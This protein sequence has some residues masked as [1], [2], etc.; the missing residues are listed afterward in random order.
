MLVSPY[1]I[2]LVGLLMSALLG[3]LTSLYVKEFPSSFKED[4]IRQ[5]HFQKL[6]LVFFFSLMVGDVLVLKYYT[7]EYVPHRIHYLILSL[8]YTMAI[9]SL[10][11]KSN[12]NIPLYV[13]VILSSYVFGWKFL[14]YPLG[15]TDVDGVYHVGNI[16]YLLNTHNL[17]SIPSSYKE[18][19]AHYL[20]VAITTIILS[21][22]YTVK[23][24]LISY[25]ALSSIFGV[26]SVI[27]VYI[28]A[29]KYYN[30]KI[31][32]VT[33]VLYLS[34]MYT[35]KF[36]SLPTQLSFAVLMVIFNEYL[37]YKTIKSPNL[38]YTILFII[39]YTSLMFYH[40]YSSVM[41]LVLLAIMLFYR[42]RR[43]LKGYYSL[44]LLIFGIQLIYN[45]KFNFART[46]SIIRWGFLAGRYLDFRLLSS[47][48]IELA[49]STISTVLSF[50][51][52]FIMVYLIS[53]SFIKNLLIRKKSSSDLLFN[54]ILSVLVLINMIFY[55]SPQLRNTVLDRG[56][57]I[58]VIISG[59]YLGSK[60]LVSLFNLMNTKANS[61]S[62]TSILLLIMFIGLMSFSS[63]V[64]YVNNTFFFKNESP[65]KTFPTVQEESSIKWSTMFSKGQNTQIYV[66]GTFYF[67]TR[68]VKV[69]VYDLMFKASIKRVPWSS[70]EP[71]GYVFADKYG[72]YLL[73][74]Y[75][76]LTYF[77]ENSTRVKVSKENY[78]RIIV[79]GYPIV[80]NNNIITGLKGG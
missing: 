42:E 22:S 23:Q 73:S 39:C 6:S 55:V 14:V 33:V 25:S 78:Q 21:S 19:P 10:I 80:Y 61:R 3:L 46:L 26:F 48:K 8:L 75:D 70:S 17:A 43:P 18:Y 51:N 34:F 52:L 58:T 49:H 4:I 9:L 16:Y 36:Y 57:A 15:T 1:I 54:I 77:F 29:K 31:G 68:T 13:L 72:I 11:Q 35:I 63:N 59:I 41:F 38:K 30:P 47:G 45:A 40:Y 69:N 56:I 66:S 53:I 7:W 64:S 37:A 44:F 50:A 76:Y 2:V 79:D 24:L 62:W 67:L 27:L 32:I 71:N 60:G 28:I 74:K 65:F 12:S 5:I 20:I